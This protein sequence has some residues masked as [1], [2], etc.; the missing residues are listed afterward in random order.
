MKVEEIVRRLKEGRIVEIPTDTVNGLICDYHNKEAEEEIFRIKKR[1]REKI[2]PIFVSSIEE[3]K[4]LV[5][6]SARQEKFLRKVWPGK[7]TCVL[8]KDV[9]GFRI[10]DDKL[11][12]EI[13]EKLGGPLL[14]TSANISGEPPAGGPPST[15]IDLT[16]DPPRILREGAVPG[17]KLQKIWS[18]L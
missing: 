1:P 12:L 17:E 13:L 14:Q 5:P 6:V 8:K 10:P 18:M 9:G 4:K 3:V 2:L 11:V 7:V 15:V 16:E